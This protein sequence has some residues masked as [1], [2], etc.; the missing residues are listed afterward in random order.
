MR[1]QENRCLLELPGG[2]GLAQHSFLYGVSMIP[3]ATVLMRMGAY[4]SGQ[5]RL[6]ASIAE[7]TAAWAEVPGRGF[8]VTMPE[9]RVRRPGHTLEVGG[10]TRR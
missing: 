10:L 8:L 9:N 3:G 6:A 7:P 2:A 5:I 4:S 1:R